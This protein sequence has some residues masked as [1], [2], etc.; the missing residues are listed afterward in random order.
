[1]S[2]AT[3]IGRFVGHLENG[4]WKNPPRELVGSTFVRKEASFRR[5]IQRGGEF[6]PEPGRYHLYVATACPWASRTTMVRKL[7]KLEEV[8]SMTSVHPDM[9]DQGWTFEGTNDPVNGFSNLH[10]VYTAADPNYSGRVTVPVLWDKKT[11]TIVNNES[12]EILRMLNK[13]FDQWG[14]SSVDLYPDVLAQAI[15]ELNERTYSA[16]NNA[17]Y[18]AGFSTSQVSYQAA[19]WDIFKLL[20]ELEERLSTQRFLMGASLTEA[21]IRVFTTAV[22][23]DIVY[24]GHFKCNVRHLWDYPNLWGWLRD[25]YQMPGIA[26]TVDLDAIKRHYYYSH[27]WV[28]PSRVVPVGPSIDLRTPHS[29][30]SMLSMG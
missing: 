12:S 27:S 6:P 3:N 9:L 18:R 11:A 16:F 24:Y 19:V 25:I 14:D 26:E 30:S 17:V 8:I 13:E 20:D 10:Q 4:Q 5:R 23:F 2:E 29:R 1:L 7:K 15:N 22:R 28:N 21:D